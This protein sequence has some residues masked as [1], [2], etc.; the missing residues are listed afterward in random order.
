MSTLPSIHW[1]PGSGALRVSTFDK[2]ERE[3][4][5]IIQPCGK[6]KK[7]GP[8]TWVPRVRKQASQ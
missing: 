1:C 3:A 8:H 2:P 6:W 7:H 4:K 5:A